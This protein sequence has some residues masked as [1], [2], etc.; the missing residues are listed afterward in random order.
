ML[1]CSPDPVDI[2][3]NIKVPDKINNGY[4]SG[5]DGAEGC[6]SKVPFCSAVVLAVVAVVTIL[7]RLLRS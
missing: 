1:S 4:Y 6:T 2:V 3:M 5:Q 7:P